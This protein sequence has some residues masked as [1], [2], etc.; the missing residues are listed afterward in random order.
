MCFLLS[1]YYYNE[2]LGTDFTTDEDGRGGK[3]LRREKD[4]RVSFSF[5]LFY[6]TQIHFRCFITRNPMYEK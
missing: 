6:T 4:P 3:S 5:F 1:F 2:Y